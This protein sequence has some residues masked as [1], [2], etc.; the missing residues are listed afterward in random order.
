MQKLEINEIVNLIEAEKTFEAAASDGSFRI[1]INRY[2]PY[3]CT[4]IHDGSHL[5]S[6]LSDKIALS[7]YERWFEEDPSTGDFIAS[8]PIT[9]IGCDSRFEYD[10]NRNEKACIYEEAWGKK[11]WKKPLT[12][13][14]KLISRRKHANYYKVTHALISKLEQL[15]DGCVVYD[16]H[17]YNFQRWDRSV[18]LFN[19]GTENID[20]NKF[21]PICENWKEELGKIRI[22]DIENKTSINDVFKGRGYNL[23]YITK[24]FHKTLVLATEVKKVYCNEL[25]GES[26]PRIIKVLQQSLKRAI[27]NN[28]NFFSQTM[29]NW[30]HKEV[31]MLL[32]KKIDPAILKVDKA[33]YGLLK[34]FE[35]LA[36]VN[37]I[38]T[39]AEKRK[40]FKNK[41]T[42]LPKF[43][44]SPIR[45]SPYELKQ[46]LS[47][48]RTQDISDVTSRHLY[49][50]VINAYFDKIDML[51]TLSTNQF[52]YNSLR[53]F[54]RPSKNDIQNAKYLIHLPQIAGQPSQSPTLSTEEAMLMFKDSL[55]E[56]GFNTK[57]EKSSKIISQVMV[58][59]SRK[60]ILFRPDAKFTHKEVKAL[61]EH[62]I[63]VHMVTTTNSNLQKLK[64][65]NL[66]LPVNTRTQEGL[67]ILSEYLSGNIT[68]KRLKK[69][70][71]RVLIVDMMCSGANFMECFNFLYGTYLKDR[72][73]A[74]SIVARVFRG[75]GFTKDYLYLSGFVEVLRF[76]E[77]NNNLE[78]L[79]VGKMSLGFYNTINEMIEREMI[80]KPKFVTHSFVNSHEDENNSIYEYILGGLK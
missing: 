65:F 34:N 33:L 39:V 36:F 44:Y 45:I 7:D 41:Q 16:L 54:G 68:M 32:D 80:Q 35:L 37:P 53:Y 38:N 8:M 31:G 40:F 2:L 66:G 22:R 47:E 78:P 64:I 73:E 27:L 67:A 26:Y 50:S 70:A 17:S 18:P 51:A 60:T 14:D 74:F 13:R 9:L 52:F 77:N 20:Q 43:K 48:L 6:S 79:L 15:F 76:W 19:I 71:Y 30:K 25:S 49:E 23:E 62:E 42:S 5:R 63:G 4:A 24:N 12:S 72:D 46:K 11:V 3:C 69:L 1:K 57:I 29:T 28:A 59:N 56:Y 58:L 55:T 21:A 75:G 61:V 10:L